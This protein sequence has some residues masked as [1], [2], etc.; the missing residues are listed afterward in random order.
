MKCEV[1]QKLEL[2]F[3]RNRQVYHLNCFLD[4]SAHPLGEIL[5]LAISSICDFLPK[6]F[7]HVGHMLRTGDSR[8]VDTVE[9]RQAEAWPGLGV[10]VHH[11]Q[12]LLCQDDQCV[13]VISL[14]KTKG[15]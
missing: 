8:G 11:H 9:V 7:R 6:L 2:N 10:Q 13:W 14:W 15:Y 5:V 4:H 12:L 1:N 3:T